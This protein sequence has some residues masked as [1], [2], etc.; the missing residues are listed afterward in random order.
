TVQEALDARRTD[1]RTLDAHASAASRRM[2]AAALL[3][4]ICLAAF[5]RT[6]ILAQTGQLGQWTTLPYTMPINPCHIALLNTGNVLVVSGSG[7]VAAETNYRA[8]LWNRQAGTIVTQPLTWDMF[9]NGMV[10][11]LDGRPFVNGG[12]LQYDPFHGQL[13]NAVYDP[14]T[15]V[16]TDV[17]NMA[18]GRWYPTVVTLADG[19]VMAFSGLYETGG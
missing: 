17:Q 4:A 3:F 1:M 15:G 10:V 18:H 7:N 2:A 5:G 16:F 9:C 14:A 8:A 12:N 6:A 13:R 11:L 19:R